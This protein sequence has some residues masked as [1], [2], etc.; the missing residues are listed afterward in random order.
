MSGGVFNAPENLVVLG[1]VFCP[2]EGL[3]PFEG[4]ESVGRDAGQSGE[5]RRGCIG[6]QWDSGGGASRGIMNWTSVGF[7]GVESKTLEG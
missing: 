3:F 5:G 4:V 6:W 7:L 1:L 2:T